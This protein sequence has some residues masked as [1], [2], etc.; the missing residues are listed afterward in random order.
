MPRAA[1][2]Y[3][4][5]TANS[6]IADVAGTAIAPTTG[7]TIAEALPEQTILRI[8][9]T[10]AAEKTFTV[11]AGANPP[12]VA[13]SLGDVVV[14]LAAGNVTP[15][16]AFAG[17]FESGRFLQADGSLSIDAATSATGF[18]TAFKIPRNR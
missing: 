8:V 16:V 18:V 10:T 6:S 15:T 13:A 7:H 3:T 14:T 12:A 9:N 17:P 5:L 1:L 2:T 11:K 4:A